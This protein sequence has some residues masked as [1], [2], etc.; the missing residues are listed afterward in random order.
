MN[1]IALILSL[2]TE[3][4]TARQRIWRALKASGAAVLRDGVYL[5]PERDD[6]RSTLVSLSAEVNESGGTAYVLR[7]EEPDGADFIALFDRSND[8]AAL[9]A[10]V[11]QVRQ[12]LTPDTVQ[13]ALRQA[14]KLRKSFAAISKSTSSPVR[15][16]S[17]RT[18]L[19]SNWNWP[20][21]ER[22]RQTNRCRWRGKSSV[23]NRR[24]TRGGSGP[25]APG[26]GWIASPARG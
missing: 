15:P 8:F 3:N 14:R 17:R 24:I 25:L 1:L 6:C 11:D 21:R 23:C 7:V 22:Y 9:L 20:V 16:R 13:D 19:C 10:E 18:A 4:A 12:A 26:H 5:M 2:P